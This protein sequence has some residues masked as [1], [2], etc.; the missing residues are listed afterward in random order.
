MC[1]TP[2]CN[3]IRKR[4][5]YR[6]VQ[7]SIRSMIA[8][9]NIARTDTT[10]KIPINLRTP[11]NYCTQVPKWHSMLTVNISRSEAADSCLRLKVGKLISY[12]SRVITITHIFIWMCD[13]RIKRAKRLRRCYN[14]SRTEMTS[15]LNNF[16]KHSLLPVNV[17]SYWSIYRSSAYVLSS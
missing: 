12:V 17:A 4:S 7:F 5:I 16:A 9:L 15:I 13:F 8:I 6:N 1:I 3:D 2:T 14:C 11:S 10:P